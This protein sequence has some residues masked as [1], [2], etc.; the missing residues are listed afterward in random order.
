MPWFPAALMTTHGMHAAI[1][2][3]QYFHV[4]RTQLAM[5]RQ[6][7]VVTGQIHAQFSEWRDSYSTLREAVEFGMY[8]LRWQNA[9]DG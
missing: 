6:G 5:E 7:V 3:T 4:P 9:A 8:Y 2:S 1:V